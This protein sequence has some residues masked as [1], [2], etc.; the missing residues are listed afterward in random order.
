MVADRDHS[1]GRYD[2]TRALEVT[3]RFFWTFCDDYIE[4]V[5]DR[6]YG[7]PARTRPP[8]RRAALRLALSVLLR[9]FAPF[10]PYVTEEVWSW[11]QE[12]SVH[13]ASWPTVT[14]CGAAEGD[15]RALRVVGDA[16]AGIR[17]AKS[18]AKLGMRAQVTAMTLTA[19]AD[20][21][22]LIRAGEDDLRAAGKVTGMTYADGPTLSV[23]DVELVPPP[24]RGA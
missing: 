4:L 6:A 16:L 21:Q 2:H 17:K 5:K 18:D 7:A 15:S 22:E 10:L 11:W 9:L 24:P 8:R 19:P 13:R 12:G 1:V 20:V 14:E 23:H 3:E